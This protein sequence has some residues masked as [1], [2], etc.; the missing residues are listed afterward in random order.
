MDDGIR[1]IAAG[2]KVVITCT[3]QGSPA[4]EQIR[5]FIC[6]LYT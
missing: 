3:A 6:I 5:V 1:E 4:P 2:D